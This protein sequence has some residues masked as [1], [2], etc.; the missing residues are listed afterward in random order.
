MDYIL[1][2]GT[3]GSTSYISLAEP[4]EGR[5]MYMLSSFFFFLL[6]R[7]LLCVCGTC[8]H[9]GAAEVLMESSRGL[10]T[11]LLYTFAEGFQG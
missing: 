10:L 7:Y 4:V 6:K 11:F 3:E 2:R 1:E 9:C 5:E 8:M